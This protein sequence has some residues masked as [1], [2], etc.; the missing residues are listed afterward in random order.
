MA[1]T[2]RS[3]E[4]EAELDERGVVVVDLLSLGDG[5]RLREIVD[6]VYTDERRGFHASNLSADH[7]YRHAVAREGAPLLGRL[8]G[9]LFVDH[10]VYTA[11]VLTKWPDEDSA[12]HTHQD[13]TMVDEH[14]FR[15]VN[16]W[17]PLVDTHVGNGAMRVL[18]GSHRVLRAI[19]CSPMPPAG[20][21]SP[22]WQ[23]GWAEMDPV[24]VRAGQALIFDHAILHSSGPNDSDVVRP[25][26]AAAFKPRSADLFHW[27]LPDPTSDR[28]EVLGIGHD[29]FADVVVGERPDAPV[30]G[31]DTYVADRFG[32]D[33]LLARCAAPR[34]P[35]P[36]AAVERHRGLGGLLRRRRRRG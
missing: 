19:R 17:C 23:V 15:T 24:P 3:A 20:S 13:W 26:V 12:F 6:R 7:A 2:L 28:L 9:H 29:F 14:R 16:V 5:D 30:V 11:S 33:E 10:E 21:E 8:A 22:G 36:P 18:P 4:H 1:P 34:T 25:A 32:K 35:A 31:H 27:F